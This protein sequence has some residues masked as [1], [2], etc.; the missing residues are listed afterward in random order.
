MKASRK[1][2]VEFLQSHGIEW[3]HGWYRYYIGDHGDVLTPREWEI[4]DSGGAK[5]SRTLKGAIG[6]FA[7]GDFHPDPEI[8]DQAKELYLH[9]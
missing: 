5:L 8:A 7:S 6:A 2:A 9:L 1:Q 4:N 3:R